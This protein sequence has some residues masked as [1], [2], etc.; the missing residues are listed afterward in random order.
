ML[1]VW[2]VKQQA[3]VVVLIKSGRT[4]EQKVIRP[5]YFICLVEKYLKTA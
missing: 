5:L 1:V 3:S 2:L 4:K